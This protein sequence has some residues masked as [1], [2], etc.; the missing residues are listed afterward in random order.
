MPTDEAIDSVV[1]L[2]YQG[3]RLRRGESPLQDVRSP[4]FVPEPGD[5]LHQ[6]LDARDIT[7]A[8]KT[9]HP[10]L[11]LLLNVTYRD[12]VAGMRTNNLPSSTARPLAVPQ[13]SGR[14]GEIG[15]EP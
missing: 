8:S 7:S 12:E 3:D 9:D 2:M 4:A 11:L 5:G 6:R 15:I 13:V 10:K 14:V 1:F